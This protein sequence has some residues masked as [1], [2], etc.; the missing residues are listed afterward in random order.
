MES[1]IIYLNNNYKIT[2]FVCETV[3]EFNTRIEYIKKIEH[4]NINFKEALRLSKIW[5]CIKY[6]KC[7]YSHDI[8]HSVMLYDK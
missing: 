8:Y 4:H 1:I 6:K 5:Y 3:N 2:R 7:K